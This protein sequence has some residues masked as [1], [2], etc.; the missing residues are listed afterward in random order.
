LLFR[1]KKEWIHLGTNEEFSSKDEQFC[2][3]V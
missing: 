3:Q 2:G 1:P